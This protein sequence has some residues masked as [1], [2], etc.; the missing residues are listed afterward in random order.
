LGNVRFT[1]RLSQSER[2]LARVNE[3]LTQYRKSSGDNLHG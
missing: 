1:K 2:L 3:E